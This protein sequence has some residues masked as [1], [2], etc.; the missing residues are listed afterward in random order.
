[1]DSAKEKRKIIG[2]SADRIST[3]TGKAILS[4]VKFGDEGSCAKA[5]LVNSKGEV[6]IDLDKISDP[7]IDKIYNII[8]S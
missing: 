5:I 4:L 1:M 7:I 8:N 6:S 2:Q 3:A